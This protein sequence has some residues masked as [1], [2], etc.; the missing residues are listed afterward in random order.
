MGHST[1]RRAAKTRRHGRERSLEFCLKVASTRGTRKF[2]VFRD[3]KPPDPLAFAFTRRD[4]RLDRS[5]L[6]L[7]QEF[8]LR[9]FF[10]WNRYIHLV[11]RTRSRRKVALLF[12]KPNH[13]LRQCCS[14]V[15][16]LGIGRRIDPPVAGALVCAL[17]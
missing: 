1:H 8:L 12:Q 16:D 10:I 5:C 7:W 17:L 6:K 3:T 2:P 4:F 15:F 11:L 13:A 9:D 14:N